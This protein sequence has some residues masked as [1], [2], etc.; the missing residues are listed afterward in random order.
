MLAQQGTKNSGEI[1]QLQLS[2]IFLFAL[3]ENCKIDI[4]SSIK[5]PT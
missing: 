4:E 2:F 5:N 1:T 3:T